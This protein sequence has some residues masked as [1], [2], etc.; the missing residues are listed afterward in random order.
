MKADALTMEEEEQLHI[1]DLKFVHDLQ[2]KNNVI[3]GVGWRGP[4]FFRLFGLLNIIYSKNLTGHCSSSVTNQS[5]GIEKEDCRP[6]KLFATDDER[7]PIRFL[8]QK[9]SKSLIKAGPL[10]LQPLQKS[11]PDVW[12]SCQPAGVHKINS[13]MREIVTLGGLDCTNKRFTNYSIHKTTVHKLQKAGV[14]NDKI[15]AV[16]GCHSEQSLRLCCSTRE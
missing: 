2:N 10:Y 15:A 3:C 4:A 7:C 12:Y 13:F 1:E 8:E 6:Q 11:Q 14:S 5:R 9:R 16:T